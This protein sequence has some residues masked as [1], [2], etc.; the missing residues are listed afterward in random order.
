MSRGLTQAQIIE[1]FERLEKAVNQLVDE[2]G[3]EVEDP[4]LPRFVDAQ[5]AVSAL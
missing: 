2:L 5:K 4:E 1:R 3:A